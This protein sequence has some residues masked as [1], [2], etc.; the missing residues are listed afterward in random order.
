MKIIKNHCIIIYIIYCIIYYIID[1]KREPVDRQHC[2]VQRPRFIYVRV[3]FGLSP[4]N[5]IT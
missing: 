3:E 2:P 4:G 5:L 1:G